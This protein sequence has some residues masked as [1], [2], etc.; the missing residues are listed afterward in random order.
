M[1]GPRGR[2]GPPPPP[3]LPPPPRPLRLVYCNGS[4]QIQ[5]RNVSARAGVPGVRC[6]AASAPWPGAT[7][8]VS[9]RSPTHI[10]RGAGV[11]DRLEEEDEEVDDRLQ[12]VEDG[13]QAKGRLLLQHLACTGGR[14]ARRRRCGGPSGERPSELYRGAAG[15]CLPSTTVGSRRRPR[16][17]PGA[18]QRRGRVAGCC[19]KAPRAVPG[20]AAATAHHFC[21]RTAWQA[22]APLGRRSTAPRSLR[23]PAA[24][25]HWNASRQQR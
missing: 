21:P 20:A 9:H 14:G 12:E 24:S 17:A 8:V 4:G 18:P 19:Y 7:A 13:L 1:R 16:T 15:C 10:I 25:E 6:K 5:A 22:R 2:G 3:P 11:H 23:R